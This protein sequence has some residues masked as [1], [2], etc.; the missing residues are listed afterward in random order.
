M[1]EWIKCSDKMP[2]FGVDIL[3]YVPSFSNGILTG[4]VISEGR[5][6]ERFYS[7]NIGFFPDSVTHWQP[8]PPPPED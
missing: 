6:G 2:P 8:L 3:F 1:S 7:A 5:T 4:K